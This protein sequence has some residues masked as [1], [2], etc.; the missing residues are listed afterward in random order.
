MDD[1]TVAPTLPALGQDVQLGMLYDVRTA[2]FFG[3]VSLWN[4]DVVNAKQTLDDNEV[5]NAEFT[6]S[7]SLDEARNHVALDVEGSLS[8]DL[9]IIKAIG[10][11]KYLSNKKSSTFEARADVSCTVVRRTRRIPQEILASMQHERMLEDPHFTHFVAEVVEG[12]SATLSFVQSCSSS[13][14]AKKVLGEL[15]VKIVKLPVGGT[16]KVE[17]SQESESVS[18]GLKISYSGAIAEN[19]SNLEDARRI[20][21]EMP[22][23]LR[24]QLNTLYYKLLPL[25]IL[26]ST[27]NREIR[28]LD[29]NLVTKTAAALKAGTM[30]RLKL[31]DVVEQDAFHSFPAIKRQISNIRTAFAAAETEFTQAARRLLPE[32]RD[33]TTNYNIKMSELQGAVALFEQRTRIAEQFIAKKC[34]EAGVLRATVASLLADGFE[35]HLGGLTARSLTDTEAPR[36]LLSFGGTSQ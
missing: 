9:G 32:L 35:N 21:R 18:E 33:G 30:A 15:R 1:S 17:F 5:Q 8:L 6:C 24:Q 28:N 12:G 34:N 29:A 4:N 13:E 2:Q 36:L 16:A 3:G 11:A 19:A 23:K 22:T 31:K 27:V 10:S 7:Y 14:D 26:D 25:T 20:A